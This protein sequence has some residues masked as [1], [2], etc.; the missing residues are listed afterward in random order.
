MRIV[1]KI[2]YFL[3]NIF[4][5]PFKVGLISYYYPQN[6]QNING[7]SMHIFNLSR[8]LAEL[9]CEVHVFCSGEKNSIKEEYLANGK[10]VIH[11][12]DKS[13]NVNLEDAA[14]E[15]RLRYFIFENKVISEITR[16]NAKEKFDVI[17]T[18]GWLTAGAFIAKFLNK[19]PWV[20]TFHALEKNRLKFMTDDEKKFYALAKWVESTIQ[21]AD[22]LISVSEQL[23]KE[24]IENYKV[25][26]NKV[27]YIPNGVDLNTFRPLEGISPEKKVLFIGR[28]SLEKGIDLI[29]DIAAIILKRIKDVKFEI[30]APGQIFSNL[31]KVKSKF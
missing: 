1:D 13:M 15:K 21:H 4:Q 5:K 7:V 9:G 20:H 3:R 10:L 28:F 27:F 11:V 24:I 8:K 30:V 22:A 12:L 2:L 6:G 18:H 29:P 17:H 14:A 23:K 25:K 26:K 19:I 31:K 16:E